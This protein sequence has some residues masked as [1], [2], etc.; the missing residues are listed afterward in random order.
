[1]TEHT[2]TIYSIA[3]DLDL[4]PATVSRVINHPEQVKAETRWKVESYLQET[5]FQKRRY[6]SGQSSSA[7]RKSPERDRKSVV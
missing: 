1:M 2:A 5:G 4:S 3:K 6:V 7:L